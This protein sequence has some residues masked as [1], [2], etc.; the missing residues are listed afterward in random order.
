MG[1]LTFT[2]KPD[3]NLSYRIF[4]FSLDKLT[5]GTYSL[6]SVI[7]NNAFVALFIPITAGSASGSASLVALL[8]NTQFLDHLKT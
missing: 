7:S 2:E 6:Q 1:H 3:F 5:T 8:V 4:S